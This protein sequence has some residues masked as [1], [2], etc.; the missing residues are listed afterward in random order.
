MSRKHRPYTR[1]FKREAVWLVETSGRPA[2]QM[3]RELGLNDNLL[4]SWQAEFGM[5]NDMVACIN[6]ATISSSPPF[7]ASY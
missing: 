4:Y 1:G 7:Q 2:A 5:G 6:E 3:A